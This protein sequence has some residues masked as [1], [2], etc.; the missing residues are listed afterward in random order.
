M[1]RFQNLFHLLIPLLSA[2]RLG[3][4]RVLGFPW[5]WLGMFSHAEAGTA[6]FPAVQAPVSWETHGVIA[7]VIVLVSFWATPSEETPGDGRPQA[8]S[9][10]RREGFAF[11]SLPVFPWSFL[12][13]RAVP[14]THFP[15]Y[16]SHVLLSLLSSPRHFPS[17]IP[18]S[19]LGPNE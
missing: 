13:L 19:N 12:S 8:S 16:G 17:S 1:G 6:S 18:M 4:L 3:F 11:P 15:T 2:G 9:A 14:A 10:A 7:S 5:T